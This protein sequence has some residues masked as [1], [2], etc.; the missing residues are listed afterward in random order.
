LVAPGIQRAPNLARAVEMLKY[1]LRAHPERVGHYYRIWRY[2]LNMADESPSAYQQFV[3][4]IEAFITDYGEDPRAMSRLAGFIGPNQQ[5]L[6]SSVVQRFRQAVAALPETS[7]SQIN[8]GLDYGLLSSEVDE[9]KRA[10]GYL[11]FAAQYPQSSYTASAYQN[12]LNCEIQMKDVPGA[13]SVFEKLAALDRERLD[14]LLTMAQL[15]ID[16]KTKVDRAVKLLDT[17]DAILLRNQEHYEAGFFRSEQGRIKFVRGQANL[18]H[19]DLP[20]A[21]ADFEGAAQIQPDVPKVLYA[22]GEVREKMGD[23]AP[24]LD[25]YL[26]AAG[27]PYQVS[28]APHEAYERL[29]VA[30]KLGTSQDAEQRIL[31]RVTRNSNRA[32]AEYTPIPMNRPAPE[33]AFTDLAGNRFDRE[34]AKGKPTILTFWG[35]WC[36]ACVTELPALQ[37]FQNQHPG[38]NLLAVEIG[39]TPEEV[40]SFLSAHNLNSLRVAVRQDM[41]VEFGLS[42]YPNIQVIDRFGQIQFV[43]AGQLPDVGAILGKDLEALPTPE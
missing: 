4:E 30:Q 10:Q 43:H 22:L 21:R 34:V 36:A 12:A 13:E 25:A 8:L 39:N 23:M 15:Y 29:F 17:A 32:A 38:A 31:D 3:D 2:E 41:P 6:P 9:Q 19:D 42:C 1:D 20:H 14:P 37:E 26:A 5:K 28:S 33:F 18:L 16:Q 24:A 27:A 7:A 40:K 11:A 35:V